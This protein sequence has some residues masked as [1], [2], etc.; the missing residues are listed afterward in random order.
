MGSAWGAYNVAR[1]LERGIGVYKNSSEALR[2]YMKVA[3][4]RGPELLDQWSDLRS[5]T[6]AITGANFRIGDMEYV[7]KPILSTFSN[8]DIPLTKLFHLA[9][10]RDSDWGEM[11]IAGVPPSKFAALGGFGP[12]GLEDGESTTVTM[13]AVAQKYPAADGTLKVIGVDG[14]DGKIKGH[15]DVATDFTAWAHLNLV[16]GEQLSCLLLSWL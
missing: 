7:R 16:S 2:W 1:M 5:E 8:R 15:G 9:V 13:P 14:S 12:G 6:A 4:M 3:S 10:I 11:K